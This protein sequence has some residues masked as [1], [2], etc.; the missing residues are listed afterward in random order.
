M[1]TTPFKLV[2]NVETSASMG[3]LRFDFLQLLL[4]V[5]CLCRVLMCCLSNLI[6]ASYRLLCDL[7]STMK[8]MDLQVIPITCGYPVPR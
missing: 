7:C 2:C 4:E 5:L 3:L 8:F 6:V 1:F